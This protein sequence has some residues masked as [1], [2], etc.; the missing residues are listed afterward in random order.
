MK[1]FVAKI[2]SED[3]LYNIR[4]ISVMLLSIKFI[5]HKIRM[6]TVLR[7]HRMVLKCVLNRFLDLYEGEGEFVGI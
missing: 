2:P 7:Y 3:R 5:H 1:N 4:L 6:I